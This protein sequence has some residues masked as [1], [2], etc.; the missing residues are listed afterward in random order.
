MR[1]RAPMMTGPADDGVLD[2]RPLFDHDLPLDARVG[3]YRAFDAPLE[4]VEDQAVRLEHVLELAGVLPP[5]VD[6][7]GPDVEAAIDQGL[8]RIGDLELVA[9]ARLDGLHGV[10]HRRREHVDAD[11]REVA[12]RLLRLFDQPDDPS[13]GQLGNAEHLRVGH[14]RE[15]DL[16]CRLL[17]VELVDE[18]VDALV[19]Q[20]VAQVHDERLIADERLADQDGVRQP[21][22]CILLDVGDADAPGRSIADRRA[23]LRLR[24]TDD[25]PDVAD[26]GGGER[27]DSVE[28]DRLVGHGHEL[29]RARIGQRSQACAATA[30]EDQPFHYRSCP[31]KAPNRFEN[32]PIPASVNEMLKRRSCGTPNPTEDPW[33]L[34]DWNSNPMPQHW[35]L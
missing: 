31:P 4:R 6:D 1:A 17:A 19:E 18:P 35:A 15:Q 29:L 27:L 2:H 14:A 3:V 22:R 28:Q 16:R 11:E 9:E 8:N 24:V 25:D 13:V 20:V 5:A 33:K 32:V 23:N 34:N 10:E 26:A 30:A 7:V 21:A 12:A